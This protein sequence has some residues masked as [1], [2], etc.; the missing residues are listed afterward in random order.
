[1]VR[2]NPG[3]QDPLPPALTTAAVREAVVAPATAATGRSYVRDFVGSQPADTA[4]SQ[5]DVPRTLAWCVVW[6]FSLGAPD[7]FQGPATHVVVHSHGARFWELVHALAA[8]QLRDTDGAGLDLRNKST[9]QLRD[10][11][12]LRFLGPEG[13]AVRCYYWVDIFCSGQHGAG[14]S[15]AAAAE[16]AALFAEVGGCVLALGAPRAD[17]PLLGATIDSRR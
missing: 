11:L 9:Q 4:R 3:A 10:M 12:R 1:V 5:P 7:V 14:A 8:H 6:E 13:G 2:R 15:A 17:R 16:H